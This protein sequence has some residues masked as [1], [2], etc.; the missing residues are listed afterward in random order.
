M[1]VPDTDDET[2]VASKQPTATS[3]AVIKEALERFDDSQEGTVDSRDTFENDIRF[4]RLGDQWPEDIRKLRQQ[5]GRPYLTINK[6]PALIRAVANESRQNKPGIKVSPV[7]NGADEDTAEI[8]GGL[9][10][11]IE[12]N[13]NAPVA[14]NTAIDQ[15]L[16]GGFGFFRVAID[17]AHGESFDLEAQIHR[18]PNS[19][20]V[21]WD[22]MSTEFTS[23]DWGY[24]F[25]SDILDKKEYKRKWPEASMVPFD[26]GTQSYNIRYWNDERGVRVAEYFLREPMTRTLIQFA[27]VDPNTQE[28]VIKAIREED[29]PTLAKR[30]FEAGG[31]TA[32]GGTDEELAQQFVQ[33]TQMDER[34][35]RDVEYHKVMRRIINGVEVLDEEEWPGSTIPICPV[36]GDEV[37]DDGRRRFRSMIRDARDPQMMHNFWRSATTELVALA[38]RVPWVGPKGF[39]PK[40]KEEEWLHANERSYSYLEYEGT[41]PPQR[42]PF[43]GVPT[44]ALQEATTANE[45]MQAV[46]GI[47]PAS[48]GARSNETS[49][50]AIQTRERQGDVSNYHFIDNLSRAIQ[51]CGKILVEIIPAVYSTRETIRILGE[52]QIE[53]VIKL[54]QEDGGTSKNNIQGQPRLY[55]LA[56]GKYDVEVKTGPSFQTQR[57]ETRETL[58]EIGKAVP[59]AMPIIADLLADLMDFQGADKLA[60]RLNSMLP[61]EIRAQEDEEG[62]EDNPEAAEAKQ[63]LKAQ[64]QQFEQIQQQIMGE[65]QQFKAENDALKADKSV[66]TQKAQADAA[67]KGKELEI[68][69]REL[70]L[71][72]RELSLKSAEEARQPTAE[73][74]WLFDD[75]QADDKRKFDGAEAERDRQV[76][77]AKT[78]INKSE[79]E[80]SAEV[81]EAAGEKAMAQALEI[82]G[83]PRRVIR[84][85][86]GNII[87]TEV[88]QPIQ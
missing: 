59:A 20:M 42:Q 28:T 30:Y 8:I 52:D 86:G 65:L 35:R 88:V 3:D 44:G 43:A 12:R 40:D 60:R 6:L 80:D 56:V 69:G 23:A 2:P 74:K 61:P 32:N 77:L 48:I 29:L 38:P 45:D 5:E 79:E 68:K 75:K 71:K 63:A 82:L 55:N 47:Y 31:I 21:H 57:E 51:G 78:I 66:E 11:S 24:A 39:V 85:D 41:V 54:T 15:S 62:Y 49:G 50:V 16:S 34:N 17:Y 46:T 10:R 1:P 70:A 64:G 37:Y 13:S 22:I 76:D 14:Y 58:M 18:I 25:I 4:A 7:D 87:G 73:E 19:L 84:D 27:F 26:T 53:K 9:V 67:A 81:L 83:A 72:E 36:W 33:A